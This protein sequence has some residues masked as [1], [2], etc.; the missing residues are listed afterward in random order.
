M[1][2]LAM[3]SRELF[4]FDA[5]PATERRT[6]SGKGSRL[7]KDPTAQSVPLVTQAFLRLRL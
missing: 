3:R 6:A 1:V 7:G 2:N 5:G 4:A